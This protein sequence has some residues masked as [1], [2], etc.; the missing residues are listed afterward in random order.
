[1]YTIAI[2]SALVIGVLVSVFHIFPQ[3]NITLYSPLATKEPSEFPP[4]NDTLFTPE[5]L[6]IGRIF[7]ADHS[8]TATLS[9]QHV[10]TM[11]ATGDVLPAR[12]VNVQVLKNKDFTWP[13]RKTAELVRAA[14]MTFINLETPLLSDCP[15]TNEGMIFC[16]DARHVEGL[17]FAGV[18]IASLANN[19]T[20]NH[21]V[22]GVDETEQILSTA[23]IVTVGRSGPVFYPVRET[24]FAFLAYN[25][26]S[27]PQPGFPQTTEENIRVEIAAA[28]KKAAHTSLFPITG[29][30]NT[31]P[32]LISGK[33][34]WHIS[35]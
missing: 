2:I 24:Q 6:S 16:G 18:D 35:S 5:E 17:Q 33:N 7:T 25:D 12:S 13:Y 27:A 8:W 9:A 21:D 31:K 26:I 3:T 32:S 30:Q 34:T 20:G 10:R 22:A 29:A 14:D 1:M 23:N 4:A 28:K 19:H 11:I 15:P